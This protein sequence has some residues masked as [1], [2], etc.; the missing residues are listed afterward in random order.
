M[1][2]QLVV[3]LSKSVCALPVRDRRNPFS[4]PVNSDENYIEVVL[5]PMGSPV[6]QSDIFIVLVP[7][8]QIDSHRADHQ[9]QEIATDRLIAQGLA[10]KFALNIAGQ[11]A[12]RNGH[13]VI[14]SSRFLFARPKIVEESLSHYESEGFRA[15]ISTMK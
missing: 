3:A 14:K 10:E 2:K 12:G 15:W 9:A 4:P 8:S 6:G 11:L 1:P 7:R 13:D 5:K